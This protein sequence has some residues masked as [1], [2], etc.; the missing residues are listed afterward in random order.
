MF[1]LV[2]VTAAF[3]ALA[4]AADSSGASP[5]PS[6]YSRKTIRFLALGDSYTIGESVAAPERWPEQLARL[7]GGLGYRVDLHVVARTG[8]TTADLW[9][10]L[11]KEKLAPPYHLVSLLIGVNNQYQG[12]SLEEY[13]EQFRM[14]LNTAIEYAAGEPGRVIVLSIPDWGFTPFGA[15]QKRGRVSAQIDRF[16]AINREASDK[17][18]VHYVNVTAESRTD[19]GETGF[20]ADDGLHPSARMYTAWTALALPA[21]LEALAH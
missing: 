9:A 8:W 4:I 17:A 15:E 18:G 20:I 12:R 3:A 21:A 2:S 7:L 10:G 6:P 19:A 5:P 13:R 1:P 11:E 14:L 16:N